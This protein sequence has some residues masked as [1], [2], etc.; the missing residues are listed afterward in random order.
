MPHGRVNAPVD[1]IIM[2]KVT[3]NHSQTN[4]VQVKLHTQRKASTGR[5]LPSRM[6]RFSNTLAGG[7]LSTA[8]KVDPSL[9]Q[10]QPVLTSG[11]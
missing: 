9:L 6:F 2:A 7:P 3:E 4:K 8:R 11:P 5:R 1:S 10:G